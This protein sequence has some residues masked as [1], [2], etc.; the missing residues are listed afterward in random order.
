MIGLL[1]N[2]PLLVRTMEVMDRVE[3]LEDPILRL[4]EEYGGEAGLRGGVEA[5]GVLSR[6]IRERFLPEQDGRE[7]SDG[8]SVERGGR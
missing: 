5:A 4:P 3:K 7:D 6:R 8:G 1:A 2:R